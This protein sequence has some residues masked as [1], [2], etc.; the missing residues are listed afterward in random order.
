MCRRREDEE[1]FRQQEARQPGRAACTSDPAQR[2]QVPGDGG[3]FRSGVGG[4]VDK[5]DGRP[6]EAVNHGQQFV[7]CFIVISADQDDLRIQ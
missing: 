5:L 3:L 1:G 2:M 4:I 6:I 7:P